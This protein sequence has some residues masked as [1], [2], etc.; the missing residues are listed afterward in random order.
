MLFSLGLSA[1]AALAQYW[2]SIGESFML[3]SGGY[4][5]ME[6]NISINVHLDIILLRVLNPGIEHLHYLKFEENDILI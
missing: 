1:F 4:A 2:A 6:S 5:S 3:T